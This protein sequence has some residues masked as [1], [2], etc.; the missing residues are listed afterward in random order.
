M[1]EINN[2]KGVAKLLEAVIKDAFAVAGHPEK[3]PKVREFAQRKPNY[4]LEAYAD[5]FDID[6]PTLRSALT[7]ACN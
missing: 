5:Q 6:E 4:I 3:G 2:D 1:I 7:R